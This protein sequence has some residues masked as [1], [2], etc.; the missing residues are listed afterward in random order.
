[1]VKAIALLG[2]KVQ[3]TASSGTWL[4]TPKLPDVR[5]LAQFL[6]PAPALF[7][8]SALALD[9]KGRAASCPPQRGAWDILAGGAFSLRPLR[10]CR[11]GV[12]FLCA[13]GGTVRQTRGYAVN[14]FVMVKR[15][16][17]SM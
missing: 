10:N 12:G 16:P 13:W 1:M 6:D 11:T 4:E 15:A 8:S 5:L 14:I 7:K 17:K 2:I 9:R 3:T